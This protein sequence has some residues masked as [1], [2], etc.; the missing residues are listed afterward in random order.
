MS[1]LDRATGT[2][3]LSKRII[4]LTKHGSQAYGTNIAT[5]DTDVKGVCVPPAE[6]FLGFN[7]HFEQAE[8]SKPD[9]VIFDIRKFIALAADCNPN[10]IEV[11]FTDPADHLY[12]TAQGDLLIG[13]RNHFLSQRA[14]KTFSGYATGE[15]KKISKESME[16]DKGRKHAMHLV[17]L[18][19]MGEEIL[20]TGR[21]LVKRPDKEELISIRMG[22]WTYEKVQEWASEQKARIEI[23]P[24]QL[25]ENSDRIFL[26]KLCVKIVESSFDIESKFDTHG[27]AIGTREF[28]A[29]DM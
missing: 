12:T 14:R 2:P 18:L 9:M 25:P 7:K 22:A 21:V 16:T 13:Y 26:N 27:L 19:R 6:Y 29:V 15:L 28:P 10:V 24:S 17:R 3:W 4:Y 5:S 23:V 8:F 11:L 20:S 1:I